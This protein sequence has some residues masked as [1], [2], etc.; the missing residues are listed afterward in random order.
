[1]DMFNTAVILAGGK[2]TRMG[3]DKQLLM[4]NEKLLC[5]CVWESLKGTFDDLLI[6]TN[7][8]DVYKEM[9]FRTCSDEFVNMGPLAGI[10]VALKYARSKYV[11]LL[12]C[13]MPVICANY[14]Q[15]MMARIKETQA[16]ICVTR[17][18]DRIEPFN[19]FYSTDL[20]SDVEQRLNQG[21]TSLFR[22]ISSANSLILP[23]EEAAAYDNALEM[24]TNLNTCSDYY[25]FTRK[26]D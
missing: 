9:P 17:R 7:T 10:H 21:N 26:E 2:S 4:I 6:V 3:F 24:Y 13:D 11:Y 25:Q 18:N 15:H 19:A 20:L 5:Q 12:A 22:F 23:E 14:I 8:P 1:M 16:Q